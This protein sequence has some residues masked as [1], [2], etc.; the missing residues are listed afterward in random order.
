M[1]PSFQS[2]MA[3]GIPAQKAVAMDTVV[4]DTLQSNVTAIGTALSS[5]ITALTA[6]VILIGSCSKGSNDALQLRQWNGL[7]TRVQTVINRSGSLASIFP[8]SGGFISGSATNVAYSLA[9]QLAV[10][11][12]AV[13]TKEYWPL[14]GT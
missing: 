2:V 10:Q 3:V 5:S 11:F 9:N 14:R 13:N 4:T 6:D 8:P 1:A 7:G 12:V